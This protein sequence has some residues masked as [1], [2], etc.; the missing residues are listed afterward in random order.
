MDGGYLA[1]HTDYPE[2]CGG[3]V[4]MWDERFKNELKFWHDLNKT[5]RNGKKKKNHRKKQKSMM[6]V[7][8]K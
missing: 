2:L 7:V 8:K 1:F 4:S 3:Y 5:S 6:I